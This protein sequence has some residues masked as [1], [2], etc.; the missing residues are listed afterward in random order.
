VGALE[1]LAINANINDDNQGN[2][3]SGNL[4]IGEY[5][6]LVDGKT[7]SQI[8]SFHDLE[9]QSILLGRGATSSV[10]K[11]KH[12]P[13][14]QF[15]A[16]KEMI[17]EERD[18]LRQK[19]AELKA[20]HYS[21]HPCIVAFY[22][23]FYLNASLYLVLEY[24]DGGTLLDLLQKC[25]VISENIL[26]TLARKI[27]L[28]LEYLHKELHVIH[29]DI[30]PH[31]ILINRNG[32]VK[33]TDFGVCA[34]LAHTFDQVN[35]FVGTAKY[36]S[37]ERL[38]GSTYTIKSDIWSLG[39]VL[40][41]CA[42]GKY[43][44][45]DRLSDIPNNFFTFLMIIAEGDPPILPVQGFTEDF[46]NLINSCL[47]KTDQNRPDCTALLNHAWFKLYDQNITD[48]LSQYTVPN[49]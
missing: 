32:E 31:N 29:R 2:I 14:N 4:A 8:H 49:N 27:V 12:K 22:G 34:E 47:Q 40:F 35:T 24:M 9:N 6:L 33:I 26:C 39:I 17:L 18:V 20:L 16:L 15:Y 1:P 25:K 38:K 3:V 5:G 41:Q 19:L 45:G 43:P 23:A 30:K 36:M 10:W 48:W 28:G 42:V 7:A 44:Y 21:S 13:T 11:V 46:R 37:P